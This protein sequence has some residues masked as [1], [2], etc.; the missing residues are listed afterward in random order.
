ME[1][2]NIKKTEFQSLLKSIGDETFNIKFEGDAWYEQLTHDEVMYAHKLLSFKEVK[3]FD[4][5]SKKADEANKPLDKM[6]DVYV[7][8]CDAA[9]YYYLVPVMKKLKEQARK[10]ARKYGEIWA[11][12][13]SAKPS[14][15]I[16]KAA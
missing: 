6:K 4:V 8:V 16:R 1:I 7:C 13:K 12:L 15:M 11:N 14:V 3:S 9:V 5:L 10:S 2:R